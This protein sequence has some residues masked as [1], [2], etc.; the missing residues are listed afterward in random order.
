MTTCNFLLPRKCQTIGWLLLAG[1][2]VFFGLT[3][4]VFNQWHWLEQDKSRF[5]TV[6]LYL[7]LLAG[8]FLIAFSRE[9]DEDEMVRDIRISSIAIAAYIQ[10]TLYIVVSVIFAFNHGFRFITTGW[11]FYY[12]NILSSAFITFILY[13]IIF[14]SRLWKI[15]HEC[16]KEK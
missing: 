5:A 13:I 9:K 11:P 1:L 2:P 4:L 7:M 16:K 14:K 12:Y 10:M 8:I 6:I 15:R 3:L